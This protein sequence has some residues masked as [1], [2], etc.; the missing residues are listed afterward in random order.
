MSSPPRPMPTLN[1]Y[2]LSHRQDVLSVASSDDKCSTGRARLSD[3]PAIN[4]VRLARCASDLVVTVANA[5]RFCT[6]RDV[7][8]GSSCRVLSTRP[9]GR[10]SLVVSSSSP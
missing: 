5:A 8:L 2:Q 9:R 4:D 7:C 3:T 1:R 10:S 6:S